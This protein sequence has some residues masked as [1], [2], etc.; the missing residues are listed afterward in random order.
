MY[1]EFKVLRAF[2]PTESTHFFSLGKSSRLCTSGCGISVAASCAPPD[3]RTQARA[4]AC[5]NC[6]AESQPPDGGYTFVIIGARFST[7]QAEGR[8]RLRVSRI[9]LSVQV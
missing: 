3:C 5:V 1:S 9:L 7:G 8:N 6:A 2:L 4:S